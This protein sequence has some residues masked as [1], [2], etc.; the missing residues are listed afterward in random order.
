M[1][2]QSSSRF[3][4]TIRGYRSTVALEYHHYSVSL[5]GKHPSTVTASPA[6]LC[7]LGCL[8]STLLTRPLLPFIASTY[9]YGSTFNVFFMHNSFFHLLISYLNR[10]FSFEIINSLF[11]FFCRL[12]MCLCGQVSAPHAGCNNFT[13]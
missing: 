5:G 4:L 11:F 12:I 13:T 7:M 8:S 6:G 2:W 9:Y 3:L 10:L 1:Y